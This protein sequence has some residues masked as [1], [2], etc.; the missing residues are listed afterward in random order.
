[1]FLMVV[2]HWTNNHLLVTYIYSFH[3]PALFII[4]GYLF[5]PHAWYKTV[6]SFAIPITFF[7]LINLL[8]QLLIGEITYDAIKLPQLFFRIMHYRYGLG[9]SLFIGDWFLWA[10]LGLRFIFGDISSLKVMRKFYIVIALVCVLYMTFE[11]YLVSIDTIFRGYLIGR[12]IPSLI[13]FC[14]GFYLFDRKW[15]PVSVSNLYVIPLVLLFFLLPLFN[16]CCGI[17]A[18]DY[19]RSYLIFVA[20]AIISSLL[21]FILST[22]IPTKKFTQTISIG[23]L[24]VLGTHIPILRILEY[25]LPNSISFTF[26]FITIIVCYYIIIFC[27]KYCPILLGKW[28]NISFT[29]NNHLNP[30]DSSP[31]RT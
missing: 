24:V 29:K 1:M 7:S 18:N 3:M 25:L 19:G 17:V 22:K 13:F 12:M 16:G 27:E 26:P 21:L 2:G 6:L 20:N 14:V 4:S 11:N 23:T 8:V 31:R 5:K 9:D 15:N 10:L 30:K 28:R